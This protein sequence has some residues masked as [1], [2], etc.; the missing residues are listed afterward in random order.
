MVRGAPAPGNP[1]ACLAGIVSRA[2]AL[3]V[4]LALS[5]CARPPEPELVEA[6]GDITVD[7]PVAVSQVYGGGGNANAPFLNDF[8]E[9]FNRTSS[10]V[11]VDGWSLQYASATGTGL[12]SANVT[13][14]AG[15]IPAGGYYLVKEASGGAVGVALPAA[16][17]T[18]TTSMSLSAGKVV[19]VSSAGGLA[20]NGG[21]TACSAG[22]SALIVD[23][24]GYGAGTS[25]FE[26]GGPTA[27]LNSTVAALRAAGGCTDSN[28]N[29]ADFAAGTPT[30]RNLAS[31]SQLCAGGDA[32]PAVTATVPSNGSANV[33]PGALVS[34][35][36]S[37]PVTAGAGAFAVDCGGAVSVSVSGGPST[38]V[39]TPAAPLPSG[40][41]QVTVLAAAIS[42]LDSVDPPDHPAADL[43]VGFSVSSG[44]NTPIHAVQGAAHTSP[45]LGQVLSVGPAVVT[46]LA[47][48]G[49]YMQDPLPDGDDATSE[50]IFVFTGGAPAVAVGDE[51]VAR[52]TV[53]EFRPACTPS[54]AASD[55]AFN[56]LTSTEID[57]P[58]TSIR[59]HGR[60]LPPAIALG[61][62]PG[63]RHPPAAIIEDDAAGSVETSGVFDPASD[64]IDFLESLEGMR[65]RL[66]DAVVVNPSR[67]FAGGSIEIGVLAHGG[68]GAGP[69]TPRGGILLESTDYNPERLFLAN[70]LPAV[71]AAPF[72][73][74]NVGDSFGGSVVGV[75]GYSF[76]N[77][78]IFASEPLP[79]VTAGGLTGEVTALGDT[80]PTHLTVASINVENLDPTDPPDKL[81]GLAAI[82]VHNLLAPDLLAVEEIQDN[83]GATDN[84]VVDAST[85]LGGLISAISSAGGPTYSYRQIDPQNDQD[86]G[87]PGGNIRVAFLY[88]SDRGLAFVDRPGG[89]ATT[90]NDVTGGAGT[91]H[92]LLSPGRI[93]PTNSAFLSSRKPLAGEL[94]FG[95]QTLFVI[96]NHFNS[97]G[98]DQP[99]YGRFQ[100]PVLASQAQ[101]I[102]QANLV[103]GFVG[104]ILALDPAA[105][106]IVLGDLND[107]SFAPPVQA[108]VGAGL[109]D[110]VQTLPRNERYTYDFEGNCQVLDHIM[111]TSV[112]ASRATFDVVHVNAEF[113]VQ[114][115]DHEPGVA[116]FEFGTAPVIT[117]APDTTVPQGTTFSYDVNAT[118]TPAPTFALISGPS[119]LTVDGVTGLVSWT[120]NVASGFYPVSVRAQNGAS[121]DAVQ[122][123]SLQVVPPATPVPATSSALIVALAAALA[124][125]GG[126]GAR[127]ARGSGGGRRAAKA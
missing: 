111:A 57:G 63:E 17:A 37:E 71:A 52:G 62:G 118:G 112:L 47:G 93:D 48:N 74:V 89:D 70:G 99:L 36:F 46:A 33:D 26:G 90:A 110:L 69:R 116:R 124:G 85:T 60:P 64:G 43:V 114:A 121:P 102:A 81:G 79:A 6:R 3:T 25:F 119:G 100:P 98:G 2:L 10:P 41:C 123:F 91:P 73:I 29:A 30:P 11:P 16:N 87:E 59:A 80:T 107:F 4:G 9:L 97:K 1:L 120:A 95:G 106:V 54:C 86:G 66:D 109:V 8:I 31:P 45:L 75:V 39:L 23:L 44:D 115:S 42:D 82:V 55:S 35:T 88:R 65:V 103:G 96:A 27:T 83:N 20:C 122:S 61:G 68:A 105:K 72:P 24:V 32:A 22:D 94:T 50:G 125:V 13:P 77:Y 76:A 28:N 113:S 53:A 104:R 15:T 56:N 127:R 21:T 117:S 101:R 14:L 18:G 7:P 12:F 126:L 40:A 38:F 58:T 67:L 34:V 49:Y 19:L 108:L 5:A 92:L 51:V 84:G 78:K